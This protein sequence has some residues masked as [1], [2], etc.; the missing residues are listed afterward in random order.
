MHERSTRVAV[1]LAAHGVQQG[2]RV[3]LLMGNASSISMY[4]SGRDASA[5]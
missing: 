3:V 4:F 2:D 5:R 1:N